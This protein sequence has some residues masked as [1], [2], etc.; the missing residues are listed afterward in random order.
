MDKIHVEKM[1]KK[2]LQ[3][4]FVK[5]AGLLMG[6]DTVVVKNET[7]YLSVYHLSR[8]NLWND[9]SLLKQILEVKKEKFEIKIN[10]GIFQA[11]FG[12]LTTDGNNE[13]EAILKCFILKH[14]KNYDGYVEIPKN[15]S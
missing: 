13:T 8:F 1:N 14:A 2:Q 7:G 3:Y 4:A 10:N 6:P 5:T 9:L 15:F 12:D 11:I